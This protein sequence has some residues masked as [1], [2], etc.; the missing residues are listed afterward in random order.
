MK[1]TLRYLF[2]GLLFGIVL[3]K[4]EIISW[5]RIYEMFHF[6]SFHM[7]GIIGSAILI[8]IVG[9]R[10]IKKLG[11]K[12]IDG[13]PIN[14]PDKN[15]SITRYLAGGIIFGLGWALAGACPGPVYILIG[16]GFTVMLFVL[17]MG[18]LGTYTYGALRDK[19]P[20]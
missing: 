13:N 6:D 16:N 14:I 17:A 19:L 10:A 11:F 4:A 20:H 3:T 15:M 12:S 9:I 7:Y 8:G 1:N 5:Y 2:A 18:L